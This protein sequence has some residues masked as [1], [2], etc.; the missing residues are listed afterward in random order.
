M[1]DAELRFGTLRLRIEERS[2]TTR[3]DDLVTM[4]TVL[5]H[6]GDAQGHDDP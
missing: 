2:Q 6:P 3:G 5:R 1:R 4:E